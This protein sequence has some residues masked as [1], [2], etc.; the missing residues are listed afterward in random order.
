MASELG[1]GSH[2]YG[3]CVCGKLRTCGGCACAKTLAALVQLISRARD[4][5]ATMVADEK[6][7]PDGELPLDET[8]EEWE[9]IP[10]NMDDA[11]ADLLSSKFNYPKV[12]ASK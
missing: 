7:E 2:A 12:C 11:E 8:G 5:L 1:R 6:I 10:R 4:E 9:L 3:V